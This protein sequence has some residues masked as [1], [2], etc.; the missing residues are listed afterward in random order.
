MKECAAT[1]VAALTFGA[2]AEAWVASPCA[3]DNAPAVCDTCCAAA[4]GDASCDCAACWES[5]RERG[6]VFAAAFVD[7]SPSGGALCE[8]TLTDVLTGVQQVAV[9]AVPEEDFF[10]GGTTSGPSAAECESLVSSQAFSTAVNAH[11]EASAS[12]VL[13][14]CRGDVTRLVEPYRAGALAIAEVRVRCLALLRFAL[15]T[16][17]CSFGSALPHCASSTVAPS[18][19]ALPVVWQGRTPSRSVQ[20]LRLMEILANTRPN[21]NSVKL[22]F[23]FANL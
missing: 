17:P 13:R 7:V 4:T 18:F 2:V 14:A 3:F 1:S 6:Q 15:L 12:A 8:T 22:N 5:V 23:P 20:V 21:E 16:P 10:V 11:A 9:E 19:C